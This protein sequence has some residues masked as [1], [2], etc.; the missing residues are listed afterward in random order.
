[1]E[2]P[3]NT[4][5]GILP[6]AVI[7]YNNTNKTDGFKP[8]I[9]GHTSGRHSE[10]L[11]NE[12]ELITQYIR[13]LNIKLTHY[14]KISLERT[15]TLKRK[16]PKSFRTKRIQNIKTF[17]VRDQIYVKKSQIY[18]K[19]KEKFYETFKILRNFPIFCNLVNWKT[20]LKTKVNFNQLKPC[21]EKET[22]KIQIDSEPQTSIVAENYS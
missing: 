1:M 15:Q 4:L 12:K 22:E 8:S 18:D 7:Y 19:V 16:N 21:Y 6:Y 14:Y 13:D 10:T 9:F 2:S 20:N 3:Q 11:Y 5:L 17:K